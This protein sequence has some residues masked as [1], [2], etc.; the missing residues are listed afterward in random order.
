MTR[1]DEDHLV[2]VRIDDR[3]VSD[4]R[5]VGHYRCDADRSRSG[6]KPQHGR[7]DGFS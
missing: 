1:I 5:I 4:V 6:G 2:R 3:A 7:V